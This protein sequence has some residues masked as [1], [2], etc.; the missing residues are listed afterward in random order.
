MEQ[1]N[2]ILRRY[3]G[4]DRVELHVMEAEG[5][6]MRMSLPIRVDAHNRLLAA[7]VRD[8]VG[9]EGNVVVA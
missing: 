3:K 1:L 6:G 7:E 5:T 4:M 2:E 9:Q 8:L